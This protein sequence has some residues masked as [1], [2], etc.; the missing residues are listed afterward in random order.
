M[1]PAGPIEELCA[2]GPVLTDGAWGTELQAQ[3]LEP[4][5]LPDAWSLDHPDR[6]EAVARAYVDAGSRVILTNSFRANRLALAGQPLAARVAELNRA[7][8][9]ISRR[10]AR[11]RA[12]VFGSLGPS[13]RLLVTG[14]VDESELREAFL[15]QARALAE[16]GADGIAIETMSDLAEAKLAL[17]AVRETGLPA[18]ACMTFDSGRRRDRTMMGTAPEEAARELEAAGAAAIGANCGA[19][20]EHYVPVCAGL[21]AATRLPLWIKPNAGTPRL[22]GGRAV[23]DTDPEEFAAHLPAL[24]AAGARFVGGCCGTTPKFIEA[25]GRRLA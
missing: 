6:V 23:Y 14:E 16:G 12:R 7:A 10:A 22:E 20:V 9:G 5:E 8:V 24:L 15:E 2:G 18:V 1:P 13:G 21:A 19:G 17:E 3:G 25:L 11:G 4:G